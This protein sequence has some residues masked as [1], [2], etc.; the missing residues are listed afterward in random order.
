VPS[1][2]IYLS[3]ALNSYVLVRDEWPVQRQTY[4]SRIALS[5]ADHQLPLAGIKLH[6]FVDRDTCVCVNNLPEVIT[7]QILRSIS[8]SI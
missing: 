7:R 4:M 5:T 1:D 6:W 8:Q 3:K 2:V